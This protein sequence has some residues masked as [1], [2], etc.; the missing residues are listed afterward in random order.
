M[1]ENLLL[2]VVLLPF[3]I[4][5]MKRRTFIQVLIMKLKMLVLL[6][7]LKTEEHLLKLTMNQP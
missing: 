7:R 5:M 2:M 4:Q 1:M 6:Q 3:S